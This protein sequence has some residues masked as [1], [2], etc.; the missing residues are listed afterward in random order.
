MSVR[1]QAFLALLVAVLATGCRAKAPSAA[2]SKVVDWTKLHITVGGRRDVNPVPATPENIAE[3]KQAFT[4]YCMV[5]HGLDGQN[6]GVPF[7]ETISPPVP[8][9]ASPQ[10]QAYSDGQLKWII[11]NGLYPSGMPPSKGEFS[12]DDMWQMVDYIRHLPAKGSLGEPSVYGGSA[13]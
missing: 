4:S 9:L 7:A 12:D 13:K 6:S 3:G 2:E 1:T 11:A 10:V 8:S 5:C